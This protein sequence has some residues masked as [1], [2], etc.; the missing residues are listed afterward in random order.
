MSQYDG[1]STRALATITR[2]GAAVTFPGTGTA[3]TYD[4][5]TGT[6]S[7]GVPGADVTGRAVQI[8][9][10]PDRFAAL[11]LVLVNPVTL[12]VAASGLTVTPAPNMPMTWASKTY[13]IRDVDAVAPSGDPIVYAVIGSV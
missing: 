13:T 12:L 5:A 2:K 3:A 4:P 9:S 8:D 11:G 6:W 10:D 7:G 1:I